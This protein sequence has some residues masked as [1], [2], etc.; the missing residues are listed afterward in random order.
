MAG[1]TKITPFGR[2]AL[3]LLNLELGEFQVAGLVLL[4]GAL[5]GLSHV[6]PGYPFYGDVWPH[7]VRLQITYE[8]FRAGHA[9]GWSF[10]FYNGY[11]LLRFYSP[12]FYYVGAAF[13]FLTG[14]NPF[15]AAKM[16]LFLLH[17]GSGIAVFYLAVGALRDRASAFVAACCYLLSYWHVIYVVGLGRYTVG[18]VFLVMPLSLW[19]LTRLLDNPDLTRALL[20]GVG[21]AL[22]PLS[23]IFYAYFWIPFLVAWCLAE[24]L[25]PAPGRGRRIAWLLAA[26][27]IGILLS[28]GFTLPF[29]IEGPGHRMVQPPVAPAAPS[30]TT[31]LGLTRGMSGYSGSYIGFSIVLLGLSGVVLLVRERRW[32]ASGPFWG[33]ALSLIL[34]FSAY[35][36]LATRLPMA[37]ELSTE[38]FLV[39]A[40]LFLV[41]LAGY[42]YQYLR[43]R[44][45]VNWLWL[46]VWAVLVLDLAPRL[47]AN[48][49]RP[50]EEFLEG[51]E[52][53]YTKLF[54]RQ[55]G[56]LLDVPTEGKDPLRRFN[57]LPANGYLFA[58][59]PSVLGPPY[60]QFAPRSMYYAY[61]W[62][63][64]IANEFLD[65]TQ[66]A[67][68]VQALQELRLLDAK[69]VVTLPTHKVSGPGVTYV[70]LKKGLIWNDTLL[71]QVAADTAPEKG[72]PLRG[73][74]P[75]LPF[76]IGTFEGLSPVV[77]ARRVMRVEEF[78]S[79]GVQEF[80][81][82]TLQLFN[83][84][85]PCPALRPS[86]LPY[87]DSLVQQG[88][89]Y[90]AHDWQELPTRMG[91]DPRTGVA[92][93]IFTLELDDST[94]AGPGLQFEAT[95][96][97]QEQERVDL[98][99]AVNQDCYARLAYSYYPE[100]EV[101]I[102]GAPSRVW[103]TA[104]HF[105]L[106]RLVA[107]RHSIQ[108]A[109]RTTSLRTIT[110]AVSGS[111][112]LIA[113]AALLLAAVLRRRNRN[114]PRKH[115]S[116]K[117]RNGT[118]I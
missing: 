34:T 17:V 57:R 32:F 84:S 44:F 69:Y 45:N 39:F 46:P 58:G 114:L 82:S 16:L 30:W 83:S 24:W 26:A 64:H 115:E 92:Q 29:L 4:V 38:R 79:S 98:Q 87:A 67:L 23:H 52:Y 2:R 51:R 49:Y 15:T 102:D 1:S 96:L 11:P 75:S 90:V 77:V 116:L 40:L 47:Y 9:P 5:S 18:L 118:G 110:G 86:P 43:Q 6:F 19:F 117:T 70:F 62:A 28:A 80:N 25:K 78:K 111:A 100:L 36:A 85:T 68:S 50:A 113:V 61:A 107:G 112:W 94:R 59:V 63:N 21:L 101:L 13:C 35:S 7:L 3:S 91:L 109:P 105:L 108:I 60:H 20:A 73:V 99:I 97:R 65:S 88:T 33:M 54:G 14:G 42:G 89:Y 27:A 103:E 41:L 55:D 95:R 53:V 31:V 10:F 72:T 81:S 71:R 106:V 93:T 37:G 56:R 8:A 48:V 104:D 74:S 76:V 66:D 12:L 22:L